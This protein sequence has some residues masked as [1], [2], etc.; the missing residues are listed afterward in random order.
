MFEILQPHLRDRLSPE[1]GSQLQLILK[2]GIDVNYPY[3]DGT[4]LHMLVGHALR[5]LDNIDYT[6][7]VF[8][9]LVSNGADVNAVT[10]KGETPLTLIELSKSF[11]EIFNT[12]TRNKKN[13]LTEKLI[14]LG[15]LTSKDL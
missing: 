6:L 11:S 3:L 9:F 1:L 10:T 7:E 2:M 5:N 8:D 14:K 15:G 4:C 13:R 12:S